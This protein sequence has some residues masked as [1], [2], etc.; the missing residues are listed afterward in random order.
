MN[1]KGFQE[2]DGIKMFF[3]TTIVGKYYME[4]VV[5]FAEISF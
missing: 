1:A 4:M 2:V 5:A 3:S